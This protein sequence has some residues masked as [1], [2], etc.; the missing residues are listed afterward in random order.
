[1]YERACK[2]VNTCLAD[3]HSFKAYMSRWIAAT[4]QMATRE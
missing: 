3:Q 1:M 2:T 4:T